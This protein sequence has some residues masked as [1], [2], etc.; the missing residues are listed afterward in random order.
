MP[1]KDAGP[2]RADQE[3][4]SIEV[5]VTPGVA[6]CACK[7]ITSS[8]MNTVYL[9]SVLVWLLVIENPPQEGLATD[10]MSSRADFL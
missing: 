8:K 2:E 6:T 9:Q 5:L 7:G 1:K 3:P 10:A 4:I